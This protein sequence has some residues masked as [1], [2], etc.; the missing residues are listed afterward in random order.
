MRSKLI[1][2]VCASGCL[3]LGAAASCG[4][5]P[6][7]TFEPATA[8]D[9]G[10]DV[11]NAPD[12]ASIIGD[13][14]APLKDAAIVP[15]SSLSLEQVWFITHSYLTSKDNMLIDFRK[16][17]P[18]VVTCG[19]TVGAS[20][21]WEG[22][23]VFT[24]PATGQ[25]LFYTDG[26]TIFNGFDNAKLANGDG[27]S[28]QP[29]ASEPAL[30]TPKYGSDGGSFYVFSDNYVDD[31]TPTGD[32]YYSTIDLGQGLH[33]TVV[34]K[35]THL[36]AG[37]VGEALDMVPHTNGTDFWVLAYDTAANIKAFLVSGSG[38]SASPVTSP[39]GLT[40]TVYFSAIN[41]SY[42]YDHIVLAINSL[43][44]DGQIATANIDRATRKLSGIKKLVTGDLGFHASFSEDGTKIYYVRGT[45][46]FKG[47]AYQYDLT[48]NVETI[49]GGTNLAASKLAPDHKVYFAGNGN[50]YLAV[51]NNPNA[52]GVAAGFVENGLSLNGCTVGFGVPNQTAAYLA[53]LPADPNPN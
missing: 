33:G 46:G 42:D 15:V 9:G 34:T 1:V 4:S 49:L 20:P 12:V 16:K 44:T 36:F 7:S 3:A 14:M 24:E 30:I 50:S 29:S 25:L 6:V 21:G 10:S 22:T 32:I 45:S 31:Y 39:T 23:G 26:I 35:N 11:V 2:I 41:H 19:G 48:T 13:S 51:V 47:V 27:I 53:Y 28:G 43:G 8:D 40:G 18:P 17:G 37:N 5:S 38:V 52:L